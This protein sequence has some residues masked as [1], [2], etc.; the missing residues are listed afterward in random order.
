MKAPV[1]DGR[2]PCRPLLPSLHAWDHLYDGVTAQGILQ[3]ANMSQAVVLVV[4]LVV[5]GVVADAAASA[6]DEQKS[7]LSDISGSDSA[8]STFSFL[9]AVNVLLVDTVYHWP[10]VSFNA[11]QMSSMLVISLPLSFWTMSPFFDRPIE[12]CD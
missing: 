10:D 2:Q 5:A 8:S 7:A 4:V 11:E 1:H 9:R 12:I 3:T 6:F